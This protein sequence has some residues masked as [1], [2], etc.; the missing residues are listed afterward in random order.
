[1]R[2]ELGIDPGATTLTV[3]APHEDIILKEPSLV[4]KSR[5]DGSLL[6]F[7]A[8]ARSL[9][10]QG[11]EQLSLARPLK[12]SL[13]A[14]NMTVPLFSY[15]FDR[16]G[17]ERGQNRILIASPCGDGEAGDAALIELAAQAG[18]NEC[19]LVY[20][21]IAAIIGE[22]LDFNRAKCIL[23]IGSS[24]SHVLVVGNNGIIFYRAT[25]R[26]AGDAFDSAIVSYLENHY[27]MKISGQA[28]E[29]IKYQIGAVWTGTERLSVDVSGRHIRTGEIIKKRLWSD[30]LLIAFETP[31][32]ELLEEVYRAL[33]K[34]PP[35]CIRDVLEDGIYLTGGG[36]KLRGMPQMIREIT[37]VK[38][39]H[40]HK[41]D[42][43]AKG[44][45]EILARLPQKMPMSVGNISRNCIK[46]YTTARHVPAE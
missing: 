16:A 38:V 40:L 1:M 20:A 18:A 3:S 44:L 17:C 14:K 21:P 29:K 13:C 25:I 36:S 39:T 11:A 42:A 15:L 2:R 43:V 46:M 8:E 45:A 41:D 4:A 24:R 23:Q 34:L 7:G 19:Y 37:R 26:A 27:G 6:A 9:W 32:T 33:N 22:G 30:E 28:A 5:S 35:E 31:M 12:E 10:E